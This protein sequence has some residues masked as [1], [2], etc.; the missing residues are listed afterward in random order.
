M[1]ES[2]DKAPVQQNNQL[3]AVLFAIAVWQKVLILGLAGTLAC[4]AI[5]MVLLVVNDDMNRPA[6]RILLLTAIWFHMM[7]VAAAAV[8]AR[9]LYNITIAIGVLIFANVLLVNLVVSLVII[10]LASSRLRQPAY[11]SA[12]S[13][14]IF[15]RSIDQGNPVTEPTDKPPLLQYAR[16][17]GDP[18]LYTI[19]KWHRRLIASLIGDVGVT[20]TAFLLTPYVDALPR[21]LSS[22]L[23]I[24]WIAV[25]FLLIVSA[26]AVMLK[27]YHFVV[28]FVLTFVA[29]FPFV[30]VIIALIVIGEAA[31][32]LKHHGIRVGGLGANLAAPALGRG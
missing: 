7:M 16:L 13:A 2:H 17:E 12:G 15:P 5:A 3:S 20:V 6:F 26:V 1:T 28:V 21:P 27:L 30:N 24:A 29:M 25:H 18:V 32:R 10:R 11:A 22:L 23:L 19:A 4:V 9:K 14:L 8:I 31:N